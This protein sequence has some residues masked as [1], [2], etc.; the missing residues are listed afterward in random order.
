[1]KPPP[2]IIPPNTEW[3][4][5][6]ITRLASES[7]KPLEVVCAAA[8]LAS[9]W[10]A[11][12]GSHFDDAGR[13]RELDVLVEKTTVVPIIHEKGARCTSR[14][15]LSCK[16][17]PLHC[18]PLTYSVS[19]HTVPALDPTLVANQLALPSPRDRSYEFIQ[20]VEDG[21]AV[22]LLEALGLHDQPRVVGFDTVERRVTRDQS[23][24]F[25]RAR[26]G[27]HPIHSALDNALKAAIHWNSRVPSGWSGDTQPEVLL[28]V[29]I[30]VLSVP[31]WD[32]TIDGG[33]AGVAQTRDLGFQTNY[34][35]FGYNGRQVTTLIIAGRALGRA[36]K[37]LDAMHTWL[38][39]LVK[40]RYSA[41]G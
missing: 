22:R 40:E 39:E 35:P 1:M 36:I 29:P 13:I 17:F 34:Y 28:H 12:L 5:E 41:N 32:V 6:E 25:A 15:L 4:V 16:G 38:C 21:A 11:W 3:P 23:V 2:E 31:A 30:C 14:V 10:E 18:A 9:S 20:E 33:R 24:T 8:F 7:G 26:D 37:A 27:D 19:K